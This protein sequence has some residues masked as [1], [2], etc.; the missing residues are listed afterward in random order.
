MRKHLVRCDV[1]TRALPR[2]SFYLHILSLSGVAQYTRALRTT[3]D[4]SIFGVWDVVDGPLYLIKRTS[5]NKSVLTAVCWRPLDAHDPERKASHMSKLQTWYATTH[6]ESPPLCAD[7][8]NV[9]DR[10]YFC[11]P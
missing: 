1:S 2:I 10:I 4:P 7:L 6:P 11:D 5:I 3:S 8:L 9:E